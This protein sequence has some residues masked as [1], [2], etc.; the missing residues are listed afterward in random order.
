MRRKCCL[1]KIY[2]ELKG[3]SPKELRFYW[4]AFYTYPLKGVKAKL[5][6]SA[7]VRRPMWARAL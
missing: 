2:E 3:L 1:P 4:N 5:R 6:P 7:M